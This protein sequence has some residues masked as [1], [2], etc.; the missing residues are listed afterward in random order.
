MKTM[1]VYIASPFFNP[2][3]LAYV[4][5]VEEILEELGID[6][7][8]PRSEGT[9]KEMTSE[10]KEANSKAMYEENINQLIECNVIIVN[11]DWKDTGTIFELGYAARL[12][13]EIYNPLR[14]RKIL[15]FTTIKKPVNL[16][17]KYCID[18]HS[19]TYGYL[20]D[21]LEKF[22]NGEF[23]TSGNS[24]EINE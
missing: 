21:V 6:Y 17:L 12:R 4:M 5:L 19:E 15:T 1:K 16:M 13:E 3:Q 23:K 20:S 14:P 24:L 10:Q 7:F 18:A 11:L 22:S 2:E 8:S 9:I